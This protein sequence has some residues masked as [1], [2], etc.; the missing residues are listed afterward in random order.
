MRQK[1]SSFLQK[2]KAIFYNNRKEENRE[3]Y[4]EVKTTNYKA[5][6][7]ANYINEKIEELN[8]KYNIEDYETECD[9]L[10]EGCTCDVCGCEIESD[11]ESEEEVST[12]KKNK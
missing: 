5:N 8:N 7:I 12:K 3:E 10:Y 4:E 6:D 1:H 9:D 2:E 11:N